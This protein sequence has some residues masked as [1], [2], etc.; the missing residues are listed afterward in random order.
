MTNAITIITELTNVGSTNGGTHAV[1]SPP[2]ISTLIS[3]SPSLRFDEFGYKDPSPLP[4][5]QQV[6]YRFHLDHPASSKMNACFHDCSAII[7]VIPETQQNES[8]C[9]R[10][11]DAHLSVPCLLKMPFFSFDIW[12]QEFLLFSII[13]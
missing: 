3:L 7:P 10:E 11:K 12:C 13:L 6:N 8:P 9:F 2:L 5:C 4:C 1:K